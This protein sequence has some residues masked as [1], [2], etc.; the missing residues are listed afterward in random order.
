M[1]MVN[2]TRRIMSIPDL[3]VSATCVRIP[4]FFGHSEAVN[5]AFEKPLSPDEA[6]TLLKRAPGIKV[7]DDPANNIYRALRSRRTPTAPSP[8][9]PAATPR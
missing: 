1:K 8:T 6:R 5:A 7:L 9:T 3:P 4:L 2:E